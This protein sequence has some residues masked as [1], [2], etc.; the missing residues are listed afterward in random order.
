MKY[1]VDRCIDDKEISLF[2]VIILEY[3]SLGNL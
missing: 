2:G 1:I 3:E